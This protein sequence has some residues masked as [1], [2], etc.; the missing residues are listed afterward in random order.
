VT[1]DGRIGLLLIG[2]GDV[3]ARHDRPALEAMAE[4]VAIR[5][6]LEMMANQALRGG[7]GYSTSAGSRLKSGG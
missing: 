4:H 5:A 2:C 7:T 6:L 1:G 3:F